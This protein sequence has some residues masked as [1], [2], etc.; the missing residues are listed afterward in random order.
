MINKDLDPRATSQA[1]K[2]SISTSR[3]RR[4]THFAA[5]QSRQRGLLPSQTKLL[6][7]FHSKSSLCE[8]ESPSPV[9]KAC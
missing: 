8:I 5:P 9:S 2:I 3:R 6:S 7:Q 4:I 1:E